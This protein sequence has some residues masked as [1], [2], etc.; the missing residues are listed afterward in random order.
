MD[1]GLSFGAVGDFISIALLIKD[2]VASLD[3]CRGS[4]KQ[5]RELVQG[6]DV[7]SRTLEAIQ[8]VY[9]NLQLTNSLEDLSKISQSTISQIRSCLHG[10]LDQISKYE[11]SLGVHTSGSG[12]TLRSISRKIQ[13]KLN[14]KDIDKFRTEIAGYTM[15]LKV[16]LEI[17]TM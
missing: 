8:K 12:N 16:L 2:I 7:L 4:A 10:F 14:E 9:E 13:W 15:T 6:L 3:D 5:Y 17:T 11:P 1:F